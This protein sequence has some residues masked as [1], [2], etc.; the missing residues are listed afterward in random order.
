MPPGIPVA[1]MPINGA[2]NAALFVAQCL[3]PTRVEAFRNS[4]ENDVLKSANLEWSFLN[5]TVAL[6]RNL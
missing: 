2:K 1:T 4:M 3:E 5:E 6:T